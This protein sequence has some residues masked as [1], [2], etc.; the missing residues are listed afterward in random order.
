MAQQN[1]NLQLRPYHS[2]TVHF[3]LLCLFIMIGYV[4]DVVLLSFFFLIRFLI[5]N[6]HILHVAA[7][8][9]TRSEP[10]LDPDPR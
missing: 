6:S 3:L 1:T 7:T 8:L 4:A 2:E 5:P 9:S 10:E